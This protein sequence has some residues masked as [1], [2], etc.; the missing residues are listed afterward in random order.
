[1]K[2]YRHKKTEFKKGHKAFNPFK[3]GH[4][5]WNKRKRGV[6]PIPWNKDIPPEKHW[7]WQGGISFEPYSIK[8]DKKLKRQIRERDNYTDQ[9]TGQYGNTVH[10]IDYDKKNNCSSN[11][12]TLSRSSNVKVNY[13]RKYWMQHFQGLMKLKSI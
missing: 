3:K 1:M 5:P 4:I 7:N 8:F 13:N 6:M 11:L 2:I 9:L 10:H 12:I